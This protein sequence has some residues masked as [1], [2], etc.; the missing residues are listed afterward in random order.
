MDWRGFELCEF[1]FENSYQLEIE[2]MP[3][4]IA[5]LYLCMYV[6]WRLICITVCHRPKWSMI[7]VFTAF[8]H[9]SQF[10]HVANQLLH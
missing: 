10:Q 2:D 1:R 5:D 3:D 7:E 9:S 6:Y 4:I 8:A